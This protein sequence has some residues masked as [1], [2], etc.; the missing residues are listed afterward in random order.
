MVINKKNKFENLKVWELGQD[1]YLDLYKKFSDKNFR[2]F[3]FRDQILRATLSISNNIAEGFERQS[4]K[5]LIRF[6][7]IAKGSCGEVRNM[8]YLATKLNFVEKEKGE[9][10][11]ERCVI[12]SVK[13]NNLIKYLSNHKST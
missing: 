9:Q 6:L 10:Y 7:F 2:D 8:I 11:L 1:L 5:E 13:L 12:I 4:N 3:S